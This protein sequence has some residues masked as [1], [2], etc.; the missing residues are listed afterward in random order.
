MVRVDIEKIIK[1]KEELRKINALSMDE[2][3]FFENGQ[4]IIIDPE[5]LKEWDY[6]GL[7]NTDFITSEFYKDSINT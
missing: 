3:E 2:I 1:I 7:N 4:K 6:I 5:L